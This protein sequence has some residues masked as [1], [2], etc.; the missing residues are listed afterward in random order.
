MALN[1]LEVA[2]FN[3]NGFVVVPQV[4]TPAEVEGQRGIQGLVLFVTGRHG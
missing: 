3:K 4:F 2:S 1:D